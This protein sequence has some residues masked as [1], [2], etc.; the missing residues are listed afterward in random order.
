[1][2]LQRDRPIASEQQQHE[3]TEPTM[4]LSRAG[5]TGAAERLA[6]VYAAIAVVHLVF[7]SAVNIRAGDFGLDF[8]GTI[9][10]AGKAILDGDSPY[11]G[12]NVAALARAGNPVVYP[13]ATLV[14]AAPFSLLP[15]TASAI[16]WD[17]VSLAALLAALRIAG[18]RDWRVFA[19]VFVSFPVA[20][21]F[22][23]AQFDSLLALGCVLAWRWRSAVGARLALC[24]GV[25]IGAK[26]LLWP[27]VVWLWAIGR[28]R[29]A[30]G[31]V[32]VALISNI[33]AW[34]L[35]GFHGLRDYVHL[36]SA[37]TYAFGT[38]GY[39]LMA[40]AARLG[41]DTSVGRAFP[42]VLALGLSALCVYQ[43][44]HGRQLEALA[45]A[46][47]AGILG[48]PIVWMHYVV[49]L[50]AV[51]ALVAPAL[52]WIWAAPLLLWLPG[53]E[54]PKSGIAFALGFVAL[55][56]VAALTLRARTGASQPAGTV[57][58]SATD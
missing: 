23:L 49:I 13:A 45:A 28:R 48:S 7:V 46:T 21:S 3:A 36:L 9:W 43:A 41:V 25:V 29:Q 57:R 35:I 30:V 6:P 37:D 39:S 14:T 44:R 1:M 34:A 18:V 11:P 12:A 40:L 54:D 10:R 24:V 56:L 8:R 15:L 50:L 2:P 53:T 51:M 33:A 19:I 31:A 38:K 4:P 5:L 55:L 26:L 27:L 32:V 58:A 20:S 42:V 47:C 52:T 22:M 17:L 16:V